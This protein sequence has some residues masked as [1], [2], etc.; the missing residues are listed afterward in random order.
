MDIDSA[1][2]ALT[3]QPVNWDSI[4]A[5]VNAWRGACMHHFSA[6]EMSVTETLLA[7]SATMPVGASVRLRHLIGQR[8]E[9]LAAAISAD[10]PFNEPGRTAVEELSQFRVKHEAFRSLLCHG[11]VKVTVER[12]GHWVL[13]MRIL[14]I[15]ARQAERSAVALEQGEAEALL[16][17]LKRDGQ[18]LASVLGQLRKAV[19]SV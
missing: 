2:P 12:S 8:F 13:V 10:G 17:A 11:L 16:V 6:V 18:R 14:S 3:S 9:D 4:F 1:K 15:R 19:N 5:E 7:L